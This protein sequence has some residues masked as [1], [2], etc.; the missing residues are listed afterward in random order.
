MQWKVAKTLVRSVQFDSLLNNKTFHKRIFR[1][2]FIFH[3]FIFFIFPKLFARYCSNSKILKCAV[4]IKNALHILY[5]IKN[6]I[7]IFHIPY[8]MRHLKQVTIYYRLFNVFTFRDRNHPIYKDHSHHVHAS[9]QVVQCI[10]LDR[11]VLV[12]FYKF[13]NF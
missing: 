9:V 6:I 12:P 11:K 5:K 2:Y 8:T 4:L 7:R 3:E 13:V 10:K 1:R